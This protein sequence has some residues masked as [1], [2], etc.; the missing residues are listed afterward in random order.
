MARWITPFSGPSHRSWLSLV[1][2]RHVAGHVADEVVEVA[3]D[4]VG[5]QRPD[6]VAAQV[7]AAPDRE[8]HALALQPSPSVCST[9]YA[10]E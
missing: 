5:R 4:D 10:A 9:T 8:R 1:I 7:V 6:R 2:D 3:A